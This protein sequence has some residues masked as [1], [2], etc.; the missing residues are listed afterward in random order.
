MSSTIVSFARIDDTQYFMQKNGGK[1]KSYTNITPEILD[2]YN[3]KA[4]KA[5]RMPMHS[6]M[7]SHKEKSSSTS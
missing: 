7:G 3:R 2:S 4:R 1:V 5:F 6:A